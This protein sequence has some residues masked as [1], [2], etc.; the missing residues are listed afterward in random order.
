MKNNGDIKTA[1][2]KPVVYGPEAHVRDDAA[3]QIG[4]G[5]TSAAT[6]HEGGGAPARIPS[7][8]FGSRWAKIA[9]SSVMKPGEAR[10]GHGQ[11]DKSRIKSCK[12]LGV[13]A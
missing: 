11:L 12:T 7:P 5:C 10:C 4:R 6:L 2:G 3:N 9:S 8:G 13:F 1:N